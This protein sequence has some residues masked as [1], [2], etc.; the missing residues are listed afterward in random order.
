MSILARPRFADV[1]VAR[2]TDTGERRT[3][4]RWPLD[5]RALAHESAGLGFG[6]RHVLRLM[7][8]SMLGIGATSGTA[9]TPG[10]SV[11]VSFSSP[12]GGTRRG[13]VRRCVPAGD[14][15]RLAIIFE[16]TAAA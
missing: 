16:Q 5:G 4:D 1:P 2:R 15:Y 12:G 6:R 11:V 10:T 8:G 9:L 3:V 14:G 7:D 13:M